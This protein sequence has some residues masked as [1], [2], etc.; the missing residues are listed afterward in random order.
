MSAKDFSRGHPRRGQWC[1]LDG[2]HVCIASGKATAQHSVAQDPTSGEIVVKQLPA[3]SAVV[4]PH[5]DPELYQVDLVDKTGFKTLVILLAK[6]DRL[7]PI[8]KREDVP[9]DRLATYLATWHPYA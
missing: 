8:T 5:A 1:F 9:A 6:V 2:K 4:T 3:P 7:T